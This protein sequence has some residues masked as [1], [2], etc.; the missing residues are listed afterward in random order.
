MTFQTGNPYTDAQLD[1]TRA[2]LASSGEPIA[3]YF[4]FDHLPDKLAMASASPFAGLAAFVLTTCP[5]N[6]ER[7]VALRKLLEAK[8]AAERAMITKDVEPLRYATAGE[9]PAADR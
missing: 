4:A 5:R 6:P 7:T 9:D 1:R 2:E 8:D 3:Q